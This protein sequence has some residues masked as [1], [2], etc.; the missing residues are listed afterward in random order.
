MSRGL[1]RSPPGAIRYARRVKVESADEV[2]ARIAA[3]AER[4]GGRGVVASDGDGTLW[5]GDVGEDLFHAFVEHG[6]V[7]APA[8]EAMRREARVHALSDAGTGPDVARRIYAAY[9]EGHFPE[10]R[11]CELMAW[12][13]A[14]WTGERVRAFAR[15][16][17]L[18]LGLEKRLHAEVLAVLAK[19]RAAG[20]ETLL[21]SASPVA[22]VL[23]AG[24][25]AGF[26]EADV[27]AARPLCEGGVLLADVDRPIPY[28]DGKVTRLRERIGPGRVL[29]GAFGDNGF[30]VA[31]LKSARVGVA[32]RPK[33]RLR[34]R[35]PEI[36]GVV[37]LSAK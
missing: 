35:A 3:E 19:A 26:A 11:A 2:W 18:A 31:M 24:A 14:G 28:A 37:E 13:F 32:V 15:D 21:V 33:P 20:I 36:P 8:E 34:E 1:T 4:D 9:V 27:V 23:E 25:H 29:Y 22:V 6:D 5:D 7:H 12:C 10:D 17:V 16:A 30:D